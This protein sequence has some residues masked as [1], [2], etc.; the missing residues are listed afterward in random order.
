MFNSSYTKCSRCVKEAYA[1]IAIYLVYSF[2]AI[3]SYIL[4]TQLTECLIVSKNE[5]ALTAW[6]R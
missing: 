1:F 4:L 5:I 3:C 6:F 2:L